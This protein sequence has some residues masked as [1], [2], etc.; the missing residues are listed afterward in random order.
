VTRDELIAKYEAHG[1]RFDGIF[2]LDPLAAISFITEAKSHGI[3]VLGLDG[4]LVRDDAIQP[5]QEY[6]LDV[7]ESATPHEAA[8]EFLETFVRGG[9]MFEVAT[10]VDG[11][12]LRR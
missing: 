11:V 9:L 4:F 5:L 1:R 7:E 10:R 12:D 8:T 6:E 3:D 2:L